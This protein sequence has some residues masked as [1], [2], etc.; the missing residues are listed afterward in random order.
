MEELITL[1][2]L[3]EYDEEKTNKIDA[4]FNNAY[5]YV[6]NGFNTVDANM[7]NLSNYVSNIHAELNEA[8]NNFTTN[9]LTANRISSPYAE[10]YTIA[11]T[12]IKVNDTLGHAGQFIGLNANGGLDWLTVSAPSID[13]DNTPTAGSNNAVTSSG[14][15]SYVDTQVTAAITQVLNTGF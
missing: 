3:K 4:R 6:N 5:N 10:I 11:P 14:I 13:F 15:K 8:Y 2:Q 12:G 9:N 1:N 7:L